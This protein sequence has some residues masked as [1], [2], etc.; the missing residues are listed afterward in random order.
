[1]S[2][3]GNNPGQGQG[4]PGQGTGGSGLFGNKPAGQSTGGSSLFG[5]QGGLFSLLFHS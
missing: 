2:L 5:N 3:F 1:M 4:N